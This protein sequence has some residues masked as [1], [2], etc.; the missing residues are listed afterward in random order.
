M[1]KI[2][3]FL[4]LG[5]S[6]TN[7][8]YITCTQ[9]QTAK[10][11]VAS[12][13]DLPQGEGW[14]DLMQVKA[15]GGVQVVGGSLEK[16]GQVIGGT[17]GDIADKIGLKELPVIAAIIFY[18]KKRPIATFATIA[19]FMLFVL[20]DITRFA[21]ITALVLFV[22]YKSSNK[23]R[24]VFNRL[25]NKAVVLAGL[26]VKD[27]KEIVNAKKKEKNRNRKVTKSAY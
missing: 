26:E 7:F 5:L 24:R 10:A 4:I 8:L 22:L 11:K 9:K 15:G 12:P 3:L 2:Y 27:D 18:F 6:V 16:T 19:A 13:E 17:I 1:K 21:T 20:N 25:K 14:F 23:V